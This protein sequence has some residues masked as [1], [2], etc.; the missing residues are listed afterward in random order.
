MQRAA[1]KDQLTSI[2]DLIKILPTKQ[3]FEHTKQIISTA[4]DGFTMKD[5]EYARQ[6]NECCEIVRRFDEVLSE[7]ASR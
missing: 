7:K 4:I 6:F 2:T 5:V 1:T 3:E